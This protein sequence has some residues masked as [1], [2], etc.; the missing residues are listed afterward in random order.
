MSKGIWPFLKRFEAFGEV[1]APGEQRGAMQ[2]PLLHDM[3]EFAQLGLVKFKKSDKEILTI[4]RLAPSD[5]K[6][7]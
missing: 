5:V 1:S 2:V 6:E 4:T 3:Q 7:F